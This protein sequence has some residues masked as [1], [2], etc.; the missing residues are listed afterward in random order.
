MATAYRIH[1]FGPPDVITREQVPTP[2]PGPGEVLVKVAAAGVGPWDG[3]IRSGK[4]AIPQPLP[5]TLGSDLSGTVVAVGTDV[6]HLRVGQ[7]IYGVTNAQF[8]GAYADYAIAVANMVAPKPVTIDD[9]EAASIPVIA[10]TA[11]QAL[12]VHAGL[13]AGQTVL[14][15]GGAGNVGAYAVQL[16]VRAKL[17]V[18]STAATEDLAYVKSL[19]AHVVIDFSRERFE[20]HV[21]DVDAVIDLVG[22]ET[23][24]RSFTVI[25]KG[26]VLVSTV[27][28]PD[29]AIATSSGIKAMFFLVNVTSSELID[30]AAAV[31]V[32]ELRSKVGEVLALEEAVTAHM[33]LEGRIK[34]HKGKI[35]LRV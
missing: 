29:Q 5:L 22:G 2:V 25:K 28:Q 34:G 6:K 19:G 30:I 21:T 23:Q 1:E 8:T 15:H 12:F 18:I 4:S 11:K 10:V 20:D 7:Q 9:I 3:W 13:V 17:R 16:A 24:Q 35:V 26:G 27:S 31:D 33:M 32:G 14:I